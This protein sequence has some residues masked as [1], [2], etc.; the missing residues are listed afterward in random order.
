[1][2]KLSDYK[3]GSVVDSL[4]ST[5]KINPLSANKGKELN[6]NTYRINEVNDEIT[7]RS[8]GFKNYIINGGFDV[9]QR[10]TSFINAS[11]YTA[12]RWYGTSITTVSKSI[13]TPFGNKYSLAVKSTGANYVGQG[14]ELPGL[15]LAGIFYVG[16]TFTL[17]FKAKVPLGEDVNIYLGFRDTVVGGVSVTENDGTTPI[18]FGTGDWETYVYTFTITQ[19]PDVTSKQFV[20]YP[21]LGTD[22]TNVYSYITN[23]QLEEGSVATPFEQRPIGLELSLCQRYYESSTTSG[24]STTIGIWH[25][26][27]ATKRIIPT[28]T[29][30]TSV[31]TDIATIDGFRSANALASFVYYADA[32]L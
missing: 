6:D 32:E 8:F 26:Y 28:L 4:D 20:V 18:G 24:T 30:N 22:S 27:K 29:F 2:S 14:I 3:G 21:R 15:G 5:S 10:G 23:V 13:V 7:N 11:S 19:N 17:S 1:M 25:T 12:D 31:T 16:N 9:W